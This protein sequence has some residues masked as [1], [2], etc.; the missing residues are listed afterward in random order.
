MKK[1]ATFISPGRAIAS[2]LLLLAS[3]ISWIVFYDASGTA[4]AVWGGYRDRWFV[5]NT[6]LTYFT[7]WFIIFAFVQMTKVSVFKIASMHIALLITFGTIALISLI[8]LIDFRP[9]ISKSGVGKNFGRNKPDKRLR[10][11]GKPNL[12]VEGQI[13]QDLSTLLGIEA[14]PIDFKFETDEFGLRNSH[15]LPDPQILLLGDSQIAAGYLPLAE[16]ISGR[17]AGLLKTSVMNI[18][19]PGY[20]PQEELI[21]LESTGMSVK[22]KVVVQFIFEGNDLSDSQSWRQWLNRRFESDWPHSGLFKN[23][24]GMLHTQKPAAA[25]NRAGLFTNESGEQVKIYFLYDGNIIR[26]QI[27]EM[28]FWEPVFKKAKEEIESKG[29]VYAIVFMPAKITVLH[30]F[31]KWPAGSHFASPKS[32]ESTMGLRLAAFCTRE[33][34]AMQD[35]TEPLRDCARQG[36]LPYFTADTHINAVGHEAMAHY[37]APWIKNLLAKT[38]KQTSITDQGSVDEHIGNFR[39][40]SR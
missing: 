32:G 20:S 31:C 4:T 13:A 15:N 23:L 11:S 2:F 35:L 30:E 24:L 25:E 10:Y 39:F 40:L 5:L 18:A 14:E 21:R 37:L 17:L 36:K 27:N 7:I 3:I 19:E 12:K 16:T 28:L 38:A 33:D 1:I 9:L 29:G 26:S 22:N 34:I 8:G 6:V